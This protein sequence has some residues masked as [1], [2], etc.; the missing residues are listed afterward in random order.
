MWGEQTFSYRTPYGLDQQAI[1]AELP[2]RSGHTCEELGIDPTAAKPLYG[3]KYGQRPY[4]DAQ[5]DAGGQGTCLDNWTKNKSTHCRDPYR[6]IDHPGNACHP[7]PDQSTKN[8]ERIIQP[9]LRHVALVARLFGVFRVDGSGPFPNHMWDFAARR[10][11]LGYETLPDAG[12]TA[13]SNPSGYTGGA[14]RCPELH[15]KHA[16]ADGK[17]CYPTLAE[18]GPVC[19]SCRS[20]MDDYAT[21]VQELGAIVST[22]PSVLAPPV[23]RP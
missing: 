19:W 11:W 4:T 12:Q 5:K 9:N 2:G 23:L 1:C 7:D 15:H 13:G 21:F 16:C 8:Y 6:I 18:Y 22:S 10:Y 3:Q 14:N 17:E 20:L